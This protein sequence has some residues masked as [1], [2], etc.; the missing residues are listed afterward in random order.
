M[1]T[2]FPF[3]TNDWEIGK[4][5]VD[6]EIKPFKFAYEYINVKTDLH[7]PK[8]GAKATVNYS[9]MISAP[10]LGGPTKDVEV[11]GGGKTGINSHSNY[12]Y[13]NG[14]TIT[15]EFTYS[16]DYSKQ[17]LLEPLRSQSKEVNIPKNITDLTHQDII[18]DS[19][20]YCYYL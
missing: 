9:V 18:R 15:I 3:K 12:Y 2:W 19:S 4:S 17:Y 10:W 11:G 8:D 16:K 20:H 14:K 1:N 7:R 5:Y 6:E 13:E